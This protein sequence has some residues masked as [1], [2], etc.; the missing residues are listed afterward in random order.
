MKRMKRLGM[1][2]GLAPD[3]VETYQQLHAAVWPEVLATLKNCGIQNYSI[4]HQELADGRHLLFSYFE[5]TG[6]DF[7]ADMAL[8]GDDPKTQEWWALTAPCQQPVAEAELGGAWVT[9]AEWFHL[10]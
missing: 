3:K 8:M 4:Y 7:E 6:T 5:Y 10:D 2:T 1:I 9:M